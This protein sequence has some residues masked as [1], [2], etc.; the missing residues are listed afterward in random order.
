MQAKLVAFSPFIYALFILWL[1]LRNILAK[2][3]HQMCLIH[4]IARIDIVYMLVYRY[5]QYKILIYE[6]IIKKIYRSMR[7]SR[8]TYSTSMRLRRLYVGANVNS[9]V[10]FSK[11]FWG[12]LCYY[13]LYNNYTGMDIVHF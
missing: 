11:T 13:Y 10:K 12:Q 5:N 3:H 6:R 4:Y 2:L 9:N 1:M 7:E 8:F